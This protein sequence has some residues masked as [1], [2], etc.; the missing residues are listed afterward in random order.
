[1]QNPRLAGRY[2]K[3]IL[4]LAIEKG[5]LEAV[6]TD[7]LYMQSLV[8]ASREF[9]SLLKSP[10]IKGDKK[11]AVLDALTKGKIG[12]LVAGF[13]RLLVSK[14]RENVLPEIAVSFV[15]L[16]NGLKGIHKVK[17]TTAQVLTED[18]K[19]VILSKIKSGTS[20][21]NVELETL[22]DEKLIG[23][24]VLEYN[25]SLVDATILRD[26]QDIKKQFMNN[27]FVMKLK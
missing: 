14:N 15:D 24:F 13:N 22:V 21:E 6:Y 27:D 19:N 8:K 11:Q 9:V 17:L 12:D 18:M 2:A 23:G 3:S 16:Y 4:D 5:Q 20:M 25:N 10:V 1:M 26:L 7:M